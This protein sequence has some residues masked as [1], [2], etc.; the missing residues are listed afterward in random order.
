MSKYQVI[1]GN[2]GTVYD[3]GDLNKAMENYKSYVAMSKLPAGRASG[4]DVTLMDNGEPTR[5][6]S[7]NSAQN[8]PS[9]EEVIIDFVRKGPVHQALVMQAIHLHTTSIIADEGKVR[10]DM[11]RAL[12]S[13]ELVIA[14]AKDWKNHCPTELQ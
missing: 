6:Y 8:E 2:I 10:T 11:R 9:V 1:V 5:E 7:P 3:G 12:L 4:E 14:V 13:P